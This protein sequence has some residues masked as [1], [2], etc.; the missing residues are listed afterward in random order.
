MSRPVGSASGA[1]SARRRGDLGLSMQLSLPRRFESTLSPSMIVPRCG[2][3]LQVIVADLCGRRRYHTFSASATLKSFQHALALSLCIE[4][5]CLIAVHHGGIIEGHASQTLVSLGLTDGSIVHAFARE[6]TTTVHMRP[7]AHSAAK[8]SG[9]VHSAASHLCACPCM[10]RRTSKPAKPRFTLNKQVQV[11][12]RLGHLQSHPNDVS[13]SSHI[14]L[15]VSHDTY[16]SHCFKSSDGAACET[17]R[18]SVHIGATGHTPGRDP[19]P[20]WKRARGRGANTARCG[21]TRDKFTE[22]EPRHV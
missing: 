18:N 3:T 21:G 19:P 16:T 4:A 14:V 8:P 15:R 11:R 5:S 20:Y 12:V 6:P 2:S 17:T 9:R 22:P 7:S 1:P 10:G 13:E